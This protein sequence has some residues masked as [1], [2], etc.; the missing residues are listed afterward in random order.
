MLPKLKFD[1]DEE[2]GSSILKN[3]AILG[4]KM[5]YDHDSEEEGELAQLQEFSTNNDKL[6]DS[7]EVE[8]ESQIRTDIIKYKRQ[9]EK[10]ARQMLKQKQREELRI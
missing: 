2:E 5:L 9:Q 7:S 8:D 1:S 6:S 4:M 10:K 3:S